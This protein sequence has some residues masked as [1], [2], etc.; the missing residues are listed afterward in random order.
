M[1]TAEGRKDRSPKRARSFHEHN[2]NVRNSDS[3]LIRKRNFYILA[4]IGPMLFF[5]TIG[6]GM[7]NARLNAVRYS[8][9][10]IRMWTKKRDQVVIKARSEQ[11]ITTLLKQHQQRPLR[12]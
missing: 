1:G 3:P 8:E 5:A 11:G 7:L 2:P 12:I 10:V 9:H 6:A 4:A